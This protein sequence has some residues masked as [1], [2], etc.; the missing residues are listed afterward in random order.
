MGLIFWSDVFSPKS[1]DPAHPNPHPQAP[2]TGAAAC[3]NR[4]CLDRIKNRHKSRDGPPT[5]LH[6]T[7]NVVFIEPLEV[8]FARRASGM[9]G[10]QINVPAI[11]PHALPPTTT[12]SSSP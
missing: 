10:M 12:P 7:V 11:Y 2:K 6:I 5:R 8:T 9:P 3:F 4:W 1:P